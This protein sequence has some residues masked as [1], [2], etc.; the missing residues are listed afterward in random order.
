VTVDPATL[1]AQDHP[2]LPRFFAPPGSGLPNMPRPDPTT[3]RA[4]VYTNAAEIAA[5]LDTKA[6]SALPR[7][8]A[9]HRHYGAL[10]LVRVQANA[11]GRPGPEIRTGEYVASWSVDTE[12][13]A[14]GEVRTRVWTDEPQGPRL[15]YGYVGADKLGRIY[16]QPPYPHLM[17]AVRET[18]PEWMVAIE[19]IGVE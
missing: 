7:T 5:W 8:V 16:D 10:L 15:E 17:P 9:L 2:N 13:H 4:V 14:D 11:S 19:S 1:P 6:T 3:G 12:W 18:G